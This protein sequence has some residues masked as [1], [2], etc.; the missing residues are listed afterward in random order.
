[1]RTT[2]SQDVSA[3][4]AIDLVHLARQTLGDQD[5]EAEI[6]SLFV[7]QSRNLCGRIADMQDAQKRNDLA[8][9]LI[10]SAR[11]VGAW[12]IARDAERV[13]EAADAEKLKGAVKQLSASVEEAC[14]AIEALSIQ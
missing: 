2:Y 7:R 6:L 4:R 13:E 11:A 14:A 5:L 10:G 3:E 12:R 9:T 1:M 8:H